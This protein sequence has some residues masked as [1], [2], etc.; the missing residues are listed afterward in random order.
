MIFIA[1]YV[2]LA[3]Y[4]AGKNY[5]YFKLIRL[6]VMVRLLLVLA[7]AV[8]IAGG[9]GLSFF[10]RKIIHNYHSTNIFSKILALIV[11]L[12]IILLICWFVT[13]FVWFG[14]Q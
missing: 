13:N 10:L 5:N 1:I 8:C 9:I 11:K 12:C 6:G 3:C 2:V 4:F 14:N 7:P